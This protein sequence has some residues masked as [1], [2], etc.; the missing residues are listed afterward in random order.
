MSNT[1]KDAIKMI[2]N[3]NDFYF[4]FTTIEVKKNDKLLIRLTKDNCED[5]TSTFRKGGPFGDIVTKLDFEE[6]GLEAIQNLG[7]FMGM[8]Y[9]FDLHIFG[10][11]NWCERKGP[12][13]SIAY[14]LMGGAIDALILEAGDLPNDI[15]LQVV[16]SDGFTIILGNPMTFSVM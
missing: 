2:A 3:G 11:W 8:D 16:T 6:E 15:A 9:G 12:V 14:Y 1:P 4:R 10:S 7:A 13:H 5:S